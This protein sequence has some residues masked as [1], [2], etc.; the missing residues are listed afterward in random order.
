MKA[1]GIAKRKCAGCG[2]EWVH[3][4]DSVVPKRVRFWR[5]KILCRM[6]QGERDQRAHA[7][8]II[9][10][11]FLT[12]VGVA[13]VTH[14]SSQLFG[15][16][17]LNIVLV[18]YMVIAAA[19]VH[20]SGHALAAVLVRARVFLVQVGSGKP[21]VM[22]RLLGARLKLNRYPLAGGLVFV[23]HTA[24][25][26]VIGR[27]AVIVAGGPIAN[28]A[29]AGLLFWLGDISDWRNA[30]IALT[31]GVA[32]IPIAF[33]S[34]FGIFLVNVIP[35]TF[36]GL[37]GNMPSDGKLLLQLVRPTPPLVESILSSQYVVGSMLA[38][39]DGEY[40]LAERW[41]RDGLVCFPGNSMLHVNLTAI[42]LETGRYELARTHCLRLLRE[43]PQK[44]QEA[45]GARAILANNLAW[46]NVMLGNGELLEEADKYSKEAF[47]LAP[48]VPAV[49][50]TRGVV[51]IERGE[52]ESGMALIRKALAVAEKRR[53][54]ACDM[55]FLAL[56]EWR[57]GNVEEANKTLREVRG[58]DPNC[59][60]LPR[61]TR[62]IVASQSGLEQS[63]G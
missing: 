42:L 18:D 44:G 35:R 60:V 39:R 40:E 48:D 8:L 3:S 50:G 32:W 36:S 29:L 63:S 13:L 20:E 26:N 19:I 46:S 21:L 25:R 14:P 37:L 27:H 11:I 33:A 23:G 47:A 57:C 51:L 12:L 4:T 30:L 10:S 49:Q 9:S 56:G 52:Y 2:L 22:L 41:C 28:L 6:C 31:T 58:L 17:L 62:V 61:I 24:D 45:D 1:N 54:I 16:A 59:P 34:N 5:R 43:G 15:W 38:F 55:A 53:Q 7:K